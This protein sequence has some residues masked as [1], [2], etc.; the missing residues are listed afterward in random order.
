MKLLRLVCFLSIMCYGISLTIIGPA[1][2]EVGASFG[3]TTDRL[4][5]LTTALSVGLLISVLLCGYIVDRTPVKLVIILGQIFLTAGLLL[6]S[7]TGLFWAALVA[8]FMIGVAGGVIEV[9]TNTIIADAYAHNRGLGM[10]ILHSFFGI[11]ALIGPFFSGLFLDLGHPWRFTYM[12]AAL[13]SGLVLMLL[14]FTAFPRQVDSERI[15]LSTAVDIVKSPYA[16]LLG[17]LVLL[18]VGSEMGINYW[19]VLYMEKRMD[20]S[21]LIASSYLSYFWIAMTAGR[22]VCA[23][24][25]KKIGEWGL[26][27]I[28]TIGA[29][30]GYGLFLTVDVGWAAGVAMTG[31]GVFFS[32]IFPILMALGG[33]RFSHALG[34]IN[35]FLMSFMAGGMLIF[36]WLVGVIAQRTSLDTG[37]MFI[38]M[39][40]LLLAAGSFLLAPLGA[41]RTQS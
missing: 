10:N 32:G 22:Y 25:S 41:R 39:L 24:I 2:G 1:L 3:L 5:L 13:L 28:L 40:L 17:L 7:S 14:F 31:A 21:T 30:V 8:F 12:N 35:G 37:M 36:P 9:V 27:L 19:S 4:G 38:L 33:N 23:A 29:L 26:L 18:Y 11:G 20:I 15:E 16:L 34:S 6:F